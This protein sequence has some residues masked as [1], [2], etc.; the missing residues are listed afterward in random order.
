MA[1]CKPR[2]FLDFETHSLTARDVVE[3]YCLRAEQLAELRLGQGR[4]LAPE[5]RAI[6]RQIRDRADRALAACQPRA[7]R[8]DVAR[9]R[10]ELIEIESAILHP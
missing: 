3:E 2:A 8:G 10:R 1:A 7:S 6:L 9:L 5:R 4:S